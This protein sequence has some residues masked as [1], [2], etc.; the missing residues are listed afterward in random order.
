MYKVD[1]KEADELISAL[2]NDVE[3]LIFD[4]E[5]NKKEFENFSILPS[6]YFGMPIIDRVEMNKDGLVF[7]SKEDKCI[8]TM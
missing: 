5:E 8:F 2:Q 6:R 1:F 4:L 3:E 7:Y